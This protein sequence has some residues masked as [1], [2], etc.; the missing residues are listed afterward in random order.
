MDDGGFTAILCVIVIIIFLFFISYN[1][2][3]KKDQV[4]CLNGIIKYKKV[5]QDNGELRWKKYNNVDLTPDILE[6]TE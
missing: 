5:K 3:Y 2:G 1:C 6:Y 4:D